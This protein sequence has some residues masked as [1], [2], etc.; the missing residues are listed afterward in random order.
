MM[1]I[2]HHEL[3]CSLHIGKNQIIFVYSH[4]LHYLCTR[5]YKRSY[6]GINYN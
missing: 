2:A 1:R 3:F 4:N 6:Y 5:N